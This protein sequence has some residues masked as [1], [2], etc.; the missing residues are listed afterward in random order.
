M[1]SPT[2]CAGAGD[3]HRNSFGHRVEMNRHYVSVGMV[4]DRLIY[5]KPRLLLSIRQAACALINY[6]AKDDI[7]QARWKLKNILQ[8]SNVNTCTDRYSFLP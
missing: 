1:T 3:V 7:T 8:T 4:S 5:K 2:G 6:N